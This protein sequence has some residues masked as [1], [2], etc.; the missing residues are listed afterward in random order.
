MANYIVL[1]IPFFFV[2]ITAEYLYARAR[3]KKWHQLADS[4]SSVGTGVFDQ[5]VSAIT[6][7]VA[8]GGFYVLIYEAWAFTTL[9]AASPWTWVLAFVGT[10]FGYYWWHRL[11]HRV[12][13]L[14]VAHSVHHQS[15]EYNLT[16]ALRQNPMTLVTM[17]FFDLPLALIGVP[18]TVYVAAKSFMILYQFWI[19]TRSIPKLGPLE[20]VINTPSQHRVHHAINPRY[21]DKNYAGTFSIWDQLFGTYVEETEPC[22]FGIL[23][24]LRSWNSMWAEFEPI[25][26][27]TRTSLGEKRWGHRLYRWVAPP[28]WMP[29]KEKTNF[30]KLFDEARTGRYRVKMKP[31][32]AIYAVIQFLAVLGGSAAF[33]YQQERFSLPE[34]F[35]VVALVAASLFSIGR[36]TDGRRGA[37]GTEGVRLTLVIAAITAYLMGV[38]L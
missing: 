20:R 24:P 8:K 33:L 21:I 23:K 35:V 16:T 37:W 22:E 1:A 14:W 34:K 31:G 12:N 3:G 2:S 32:T 15:E 7:A 29:N 10:D 6:L 36:L 5:V 19:H 38:R 30:K 28:E 25:T 18:P 11:S 26:S 9:D 17:A 13:F 27:L 4:L